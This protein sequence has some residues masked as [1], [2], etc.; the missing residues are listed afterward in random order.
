MKFS[1]ERFVPNATDRDMAVEHLQRYFAITELVKDKVVLDAA[2]GEG[3]GSFILSE[4]AKNI[5]GVDISAEAIVHAQLT[6]AKSNVTFV[7]GSI[8]QLPAADH[9]VDVVVSFETIE[10]VDESI[11]HRFLKEIK[12]V[13][14]PEGIL[15]MS[16]PD[17]YVYSD[18]AN[19]RNSFHLREFYKEEFYSFLKEYFNN[20][21][22]YYQK[23]EVSSLIVNNRSDNVKRIHIEHNDHVTNGKY[24]IAVCSNES[25]TDI[26]LNSFVPDHQ[27]QHYQMIERILSLQ[28][29]VE[30]RNQHIKHLDGIIVDKDR[31]IDQVDNKLSF[32]HEQLDHQNSTVSQA[33]N[34]V[35]SMENQLKENSVKLLEALLKVASQ[36]EQL[37]KLQEELRAKDEIIESMNHLHHELNSQYEEHSAAIG[38]GILEKDQT[39]NNQIA[40]I[41][42][43]LEQERKLNNILHSGGW[44]ALSK[45]YRLR[46]TILPDNSK[47]KLLAKL[48]YKALK[49]PKQ[50]LNKINKNNIKKLKYYLNTEDPGLVESRID[51][52]LDRH[53]NVEHS[54]A[55]KIYQEIDTSQKLIFPVTNNP[56]VSIIIPVYNQWHYTYACLKSILDHTNDVAYEIIIADDMS[57]DETVNVQEYVQNVKVVRDGTNRGFLLNCNNASEYAEGKYI[58]FLNNDTNVQP[59]WLSSLVELIERDETIGMVGSKLVYPDGRQQEA[60]GI[61]WND[62]SGWNYGRLD[63]PAKS[64]Y[65]Y[66]KE[67]DYISGAAIMIRH[68]L[69]KVI[70]GFDER[71]APA[72]FEDSDLAFEV[73]QRGFKV[74]LQPRSIVV[75]FEGVSHGTDVSS[76]V[77]SYQVANKDKF[78]D[79]WRDLLSKEQFSNAEHV[80]LARD[81]SRNKKTILVID[82]Y[83]PHYDKDAGSRTVFQYLKLFVELGMNV[84]FVGDNYF[85]HEPYTTALEQMGVEVLYGNWYA[86]HFVDWLKRNGSYIDYTYLNRPH[87]SIKYIDDIKRYT[88]SKIFYYG[89][90]LHY[91]RE[92]RE[93]ELTGKE[94]LLKSA[95]DWRN[96][97][98]K[99]IAQSDVVYYPSQVEVIELKDQFPNTKIKAIPGYIYE[100]FSEKSTNQLPFSERFDLL[101]VGGFGHKPNIDAVL[102]FAEEIFPEVL[103][104]IPTI[105]WYIVGSNP[106]ELIK[107]L[108]SENIIVTGFVTDE[109]LE[110]Y[111]SQCK[112]VVVPLRFGA[113]VK[114]KVI[115]AMYHRVPIITTSV[116]SEGLQEAF[117]YLI[118]CNDSRQFADT[119]VQLYFDNER[120]TE[121]SQKSQRFVQRYYSK[122]SVIQTIKEDFSI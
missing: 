111:Y 112:M 9:S 16:T 32:V 11:Q 60:G 93:Y 23:H 59:E 63:D 30:E 35:N 66:I 78:I 106:P 120:L 108:H 25:L 115:E 20:I 52:F 107:S 41:N 27:E 88:S 119:I 48:T 49:N 37:H 2:S 26:N 43:L 15:V 45:Y 92:Q 10:H 40:H 6:Y 19:Y 68:E 34:I 100:N 80:F 98:F 57:T 122:E 46:D 102:W 65:N 89:H 117:E 53:A 101:F 50:I 118:E 22:M 55:L 5:V 44:R 105:K 17:K 47:R 73:R 90:D 3:Y 75:H 109:E 84:K 14:K 58:F 56:L 31:H 79:K 113:G 67:V 95:E 4:Y 87:I 74:M 103:N 96:I 36:E 110:K 51:N 7:Q 69:W 116:G 114:G 71:Y 39:I 86:T 85:K 1:G 72:Y 94:E 8:E 13:L 81:R 38:N 18:R 62:A 29:E 82:H 64:E 121:L 99:L 28:N 70:G 97:E 83:V 77:K 54:A 76:G 12:R 91:L 24:L 21:D 61:I 42:M 104:A 33:L